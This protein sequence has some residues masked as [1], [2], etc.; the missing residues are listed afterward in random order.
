MPPARVHR[1][2][3]ASLLVL[4]LAVMVAVLSACGSSALQ[5]INSTRTLRNDPN[6]TNGKDNE[7]PN[8]GAPCTP[9][10]EQTSATTSTSTTKSPPTTVPPINWSEANN[11]TVAK[12]ETSF[13]AACKGRAVSKS[14]VYA[15]SS[16]PLVMVGPDPDPEI[17]ANWEHYLGGDDYAEVI[18]HAPP[19]TLRPRFAKDVQLVACITEK[20]RPAPSC[21]TYLR[22]SDGVSGELRRTRATD[23]VRIFVARTGREVGQNRFVGSPESCGSEESDP[24]G[25]PPWVL[26]GDPPGLDH[27]SDHY[28][29]GFT[30][31]PGRTRE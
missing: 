22:Q 26:A 7:L 21:G 18:G 23:T 8:Q 19:R 30:T 28:I 15:G 10:Q 12:L 25:N 31:G 27:A 3:S 24:G 17:S 20:M 29:V 6:C 5:G 1:S 11:D 4:A 9:V 13:S 2:P 16:H 14:A